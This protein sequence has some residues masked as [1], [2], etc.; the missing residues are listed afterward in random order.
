V[1]AVDVLR[2]GLSGHQYPALCALSD[3]PQG[4]AAQY[5]SMQDFVF[6]CGPGTM[7]NAGHSN[8]LWTFLMPFSRFFSHYSGQI[9]KIDETLPRA[10][11]EATLHRVFQRTVQ[12][13]FDREY[14]GILCNALSSCAFT[15]GLFSQDGQGEQLDDSDLLV[16]TLAEY[17]V[18]TSRENLMWF[19]QA[20]WAQSIDLKQQ[21]GWRPPTA[22]DLPRRVYEG[23][24]LVLEQ[25]VAEL[26]RW[27]DLLIDEW[28]TQAQAVLNKFGY[29]T[30]WLA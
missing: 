5:P 20:F 23:L 2:R 28:K 7:G 1:T 25:P 14:F 19:A 17:G 27:M 18:H 26:A 9:Y 10:P 22:Q 6:T 30:D 4:L 21:Y 13:V 3:G 11:D 16:R 8:A 12:R 29:E 24:Q 15:F